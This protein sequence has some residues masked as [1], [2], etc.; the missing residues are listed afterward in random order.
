MIDCVKCHLKPGLVAH[1]V[2]AGVAVPAPGCAGCHPGLTAD[3]ENTLPPGYA[4][5]GLD[6][7]DGSNGDDGLVD[8]EDPDCCASTTPARLLRLALESKVKK[9]S[10]NRLRLRVRCRTD[11]PL[12]LDPTATDAS[13]QISDAKG[14]LFCQMVPAENWEIRRRTYRVKFRQRSLL[15]G[16]AEGLFRTRR[17]GQLHFAGSGEYTAL[18]S[19]EGDRVAVTL[20]VGGPCLRTTGELPIRQARRP[21]SMRLRFP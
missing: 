20:R 7:C 12:G 9:A 21:R 6:P 16:L 19:T 2:N 3:P 13:V 4:E 11:E 18:R 17:N 1:H 10:L 8:Y 15:T 5:A 14:Q